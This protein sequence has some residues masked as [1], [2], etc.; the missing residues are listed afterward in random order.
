MVQT[1]GRNAR[2]AVKKDAKRKSVYQKKRGIRVQGGEG[3]GG[4]SVIK[5]AENL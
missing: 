5:G 4:K 3:R 1:A 2:D